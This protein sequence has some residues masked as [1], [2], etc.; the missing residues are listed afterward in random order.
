FQGKQDFMAKNVHIG[1]T[2]QHQASGA[3][4][5]YIIK[6]LF[7]KP[8]Y[9]FFGRNYA[10]FDLRGL[11]GAGANKDSWMIPDYGLFDAM[12]GYEFN[13]QGLKFNLNVN[14]NNVL[15]TVYINDAQNN[16]SS[17]QDYDANSAAVFFGPGRT[18]VVGLKVTF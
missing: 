1:N 7:V 5:Y 6:G 11:N 10:N 13:Y 2:A 18:Y 12:A 14:V 17:Q 15:N 9:T 8:R 16:N 4:K 3:V